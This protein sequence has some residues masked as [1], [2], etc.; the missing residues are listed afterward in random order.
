MSDN[1]LVFPIR[2]FFFALLIFAGISLHSSVSADWNIYKRALL[3]NN[4]G[5]Q[6]RFDTT[7]NAIRIM[8]YL[9]SNDKDVFADRLPS[10]RVDENV[11]HRIE[12]GHEDYPGLRVNENRWLRWTISPKDELSS[13]LLEFMN[14][15]EAVFQYYRQNGQVVETVFQLEGIQEAINDIRQ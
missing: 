13:R 2:L 4:D 8:F 7:S 11:V 15:K 12:K 3:R 5:N 14:G 1:K 6:I 10:Y 9:R